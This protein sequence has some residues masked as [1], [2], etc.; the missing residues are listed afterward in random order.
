MAGMLV[1][2][3]CSAETTN[4][5]VNE[6]LITEAPETPVVT[7]EPVIIETPEVIETPEITVT[8]PVETSGTYADVS[9]LGIWY[10]VDDVDWQRADNTDFV[11]DFQDDG[12]A[13][14]TLWGGVASGSWTFDEITQKGVFIHDGSYFDFWLENDNL[15]LP[16]GEGAEVWKFSR[17][18]GEI[19]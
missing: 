16:Q 11:F 17:T 19:H 14:L 6:V 8:E 18:M 10:R 2:S 9:I 13:Q 12:Q 1:F 4:D 7:E 3:A 5:P 15:L